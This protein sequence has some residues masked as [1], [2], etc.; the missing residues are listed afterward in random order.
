[1]TFETILTHA[2]PVMVL[3]GVILAAQRKFGRPAAKRPALVL[4]LGL[5]FGLAIRAAKVDV[6]PPDMAAL[7]ASAG[8][9]LFGFAS[10]AQIRVSRLAATCPESLALTTRAAPLFFVICTLTTFIMLPSI[11]MAVAALISAALMLNGAA[12]DRA[13]ISGAP[14][15]R[16]VKRIVKLEGAAV[17]VLGVPVAVFAAAIAATPGMGE[18]AAGPLLSASFGVFKGFLFGG[19]FGLASGLLGTFLRKTV[20]RR[21]ADM[22]VAP[23][24]AAA[25]FGLSPAI[26]ADPI[27]AATAAGLLW[28]EQTKGAAATRTQLNLLAERLIC[29]TT[30]FWFGA[31]VLPRIFS[32]ELLPVL[33]AVSAVTIL[34]AGPRLAILQRT[35]LPPESQRFLAWYGGAPG[36]G[37]ALFLMTLIGNPAISDIDTILNVGALCVGAGVIIARGS[38]KPLIS[39]LLRQTAN[40]RRRRAY[41]E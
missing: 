29:P 9:G 41:T 14:T 10:A 32:A 18:P 17:V 2:V 3:L 15:P 21:R 16:V 8:L 39:E 20:K 19:A 25:S 26:G 22:Y 24:A 34:R 28:G 31:L 1:M 13:A 11:G 27:V 4:A 7:F 36:A 12:F 6:M 23:I 35:K 30:Y 37:T 38:S 5:F 33:L 40:A